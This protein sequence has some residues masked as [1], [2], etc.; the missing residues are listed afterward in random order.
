MHLP[1][2]LCSGSGLSPERP[3]LLGLLGLSL[4]LSHHPRLSSRQGVPSSGSHSS[5]VVP[6]GPP[7]PS[8]LSPCDKAPCFESEMFPT[9]SCTEGL[10]LRWQC[11]L[12]T[13]L[14]VGP[15]WRKT[16][17]WGW[18]LEVTAWPLVSAWASA[19]WCPGM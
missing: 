18:T 15:S 8:W 2:R 6:G 16:V 7:A 11:Y 13:P 19:S 3:P 14:E 4:C 1:V 10:V 9:S 5:L 12:W 17:P